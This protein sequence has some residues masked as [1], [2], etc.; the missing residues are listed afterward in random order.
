MTAVEL[1]LVLKPIESS[2]RKKKKQAFD[3][4][5]AMISSSYRNSGSD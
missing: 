4:I 1:L 2:R 5:D 3:E